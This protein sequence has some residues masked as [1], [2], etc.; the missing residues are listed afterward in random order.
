MTSKIV[1]TALVIGATGLVGK[2]L[3]SQLLVDD[4]FTTV[5]I[6]VRRSSGISNP[7]LEERIVDF[8]A[9]I[10]VNF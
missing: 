1:R 4:Y 8:D 6:F 5:K 9:Y 2:E 10:F 7:K 3:V